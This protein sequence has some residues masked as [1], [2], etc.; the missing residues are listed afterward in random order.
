MLRPVHVAERLLHQLFQ[1]PYGIFGTV[2]QAEPNDGIHPFCMAFVTD[3]V[4]VSAFCLTAFLFMADR[5]FHKF[6]FFGI[7]QRRP[8]YQ[9]FILVFLI[10]PLFVMQFKGYDVTVTGA[11]VEMVELQKENRGRRLFSW[12]CCGFP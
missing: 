3:I 9:A 6:I 2:F 4:S 8:A 12:G 7:L 10:I 11:S 5:A 1:D